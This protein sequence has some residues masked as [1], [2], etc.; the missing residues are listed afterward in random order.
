[1][2]WMVNAMTQ[3]NHID[4]TGAVIQGILA[5]LG[6]QIWR[7]NLVKLVYLADNRFYECV[8]ET[9]TGN[10]Y[11]WDNFGPNAVDNAIVKSADSLLR[12]GNLRANTSLSMQ[13]NRRH[14]YWVEN[15]EEVWDEVASLLDWGE[16]QIL[17]DIVK[18]YGSV[19]SAVRLAEMSKQTKPFENAKQY[20]ILRFK[21]NERAK[22]L[23][24]WLDSIDGLKEEIE[25]GLADMEA[26]RMVWADELED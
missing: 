4:K 1:M 18:E 23:Q 24:Q 25:L 19:N 10:E 2:E 21:Q 20:D 7:T 13:G 26:G 16:Q 12:A 11:W 6:R 9:I 15:P 14:Q 22:E 8:G 3:P 5:L 17:R